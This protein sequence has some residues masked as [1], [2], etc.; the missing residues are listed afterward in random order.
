MSFD[1]SPLDDTHPLGP[2]WVKKLQTVA[3]ESGSLGT[4]S[5]AEPN[6]EWWPPST[7]SNLTTVPP[8]QLDHVD[9][10]V[11]PLTL[12]VGSPAQPFSVT[13]CWIASALPV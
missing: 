3:S 2:R 13:H 10:L 6:H 5:K 12:R 9:V 7:V 8:W 11:M 4:G 1:Q